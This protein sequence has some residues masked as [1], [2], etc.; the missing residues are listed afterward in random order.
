MARNWKHD[1][2]FFNKTKQNLVCFKKNKEASD[3]F[4]KFEADTEVQ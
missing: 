4:S 3:V 1:I 2:I